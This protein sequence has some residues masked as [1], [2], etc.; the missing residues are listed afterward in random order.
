MAKR[1]QPNQKNQQNQQNQQNQ[2]QQPGQGLQQGANNFY[3][4]AE[5]LTRGGQREHG[6]RNQKN[7]PEKQ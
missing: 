6:A 1:K 4:T 7:N 2:A 3:E 5:E